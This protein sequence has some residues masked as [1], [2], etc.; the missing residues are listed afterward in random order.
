MKQFFEKI[1]K[2]EIRNIIAV[3]AVVGSFALLA[4]LVFKPIPKGNENTLNQSI[5]FVLGGLVGGVTGF[6]FGAS[7]SGDEKNNDAEK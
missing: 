1:G 2:A 7:K 3:L 5:G 6:F 4:L